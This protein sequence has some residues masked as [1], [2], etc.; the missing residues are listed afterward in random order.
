MLEVPL[1]A[2]SQ[3]RSHA[4]VK[5]HKNKHCVSRVHTVN[6]VQIWLVCE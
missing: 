1:S 4:I 2:L 6:F 5:S 3:M